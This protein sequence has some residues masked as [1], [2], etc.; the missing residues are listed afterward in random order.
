LI[1]N[2]VESFERLIR[3]ALEKKVED[4]A[5][6]ELGS[7]GGTFVSDMLAIA[8][9]TLETYLAPVDST[10]SD[11]LYLESILNFPPYMKMMNLQDTENI[12]GK[13]FNQMLEQIDAM[14]GTEVSDPQAPN[15]TGR[16]GRSA[17]HF[18]CDTV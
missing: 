10:V 18:R 16:R 9:T 7:L 14:L 8:E 11:P 4:V 2:I 15:G 5:C 1:L 12:I 3:N 17:Q 6:V 13:W